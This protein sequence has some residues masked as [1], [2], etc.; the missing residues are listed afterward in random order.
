MSELQRGIL[1]VTKK[2]QRTM[3]QVLIDGKPFNL[4]QGELSCKLTPSDGL[5]VEFLRVGGQPKQV[6]P[7]GEPFV[8]PQAAQASQKG[9]SKRGSKHGEGRPQNSAPSGRSRQGQPEI[10]DQETSP[11]EQRVRDFHN[12]YNFV[13]APPRKT[14]LTDLGDA[15]P[16]PQDSFDPRRYTGSIRVRMVAKTPVLVP[17]TDPANVREDANGHK[18][19]ALRVDANGLPAIPSSSVRGM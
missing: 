17:D 18:T 15:P 10:A 14:N 7:L 1:K 12:P 4:A 2:G 6:R 5:E 16:I 9:R 3:V 13:P 8:A 11:R 19:F